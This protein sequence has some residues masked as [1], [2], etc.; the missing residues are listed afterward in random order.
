MFSA[1]NFIKPVSI[2]EAYELNQK[3]ANRIIGGMCWL[4]LS[5]SN[6]Q[7]IID[8]SGLGLDKIEE[9]E[10]GFRIGAM[11]TLRMTE[12]NE[13]INKAFC[14][15]PEEC[16]KNIVGVQFRNLATIG[17]SIWSRFGFSDLLTAYMALDADVELYKGGRVKLCDFAK[18][19]PDNDIL[20]GIYVPK[21]KVK[22][23]YQ[24]I[25]NTKTD[26]PVITCCVCLNDGGINVAVGARPKKAELLHFENG[27]PTDMIAERCMKELSFG[28]NMRAGEEYRRHTAGVL[29]RRCLAEVEYAY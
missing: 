28:V 4:R 10:S 3:R 2:E 20:T 22:A 6:F 5:D 24:T 14:S 16:V 1:K 13:E 25:R 27:V 26:I 17:G 19:K 21:K 9:D 12:K 15:V 11:A 29:I 7:N 18:M 8:L 23:A